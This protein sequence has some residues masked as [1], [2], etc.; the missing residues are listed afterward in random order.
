M[1]VESEL[2][3]LA[4]LNVLSSQIKMAESFKAVAKNMESN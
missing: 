2:L 1:L 3:L 4:I